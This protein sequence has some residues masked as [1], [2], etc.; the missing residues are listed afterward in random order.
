MS[1]AR[2]SVRLRV[3]R[4]RRDGRGPCG[5]WYGS[6]QKSVTAVM[7]PL[8]S[9]EKKWMPS[10]SVPPTVN[11]VRAAACPPRPSGPAP[12]GDSGRSA[13]IR[14]IRTCQSPGYSRLNRT[15][16]SLPRITSRV[17][18]T[19]NTTSSSRVAANASQSRASAAVQYV[20]T[21]LRRTAVE[22]VPALIS[23]VMERVWTPPLTIAPTCENGQ[24][25][26]LVGPVA[27]ACDHAARTTHHLS[28]ARSGA[29]RR[30]GRRKLEQDEL[31]D[32][33]AGR[34]GPCAASP[35]RGLMGA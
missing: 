2:A 28:R 9:N 12:A 13:T 22:T 7:R 25:L 8:A 16:R 31:S 15:H 23:A 30:E 35:V 1:G 10:N 27:P 21:V 26:L 6:G 14:S 18:G 17:C 5:G 32:R 34:E 4:A 11:S 19:S 24:L 29:F 20:S 33:F 3:R